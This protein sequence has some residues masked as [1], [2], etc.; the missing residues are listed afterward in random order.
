[1]D[2]PPSGYAGWLRQ[3]VALHTT[4]LTNWGLLR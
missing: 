4:S 3:A 1:M 2:I